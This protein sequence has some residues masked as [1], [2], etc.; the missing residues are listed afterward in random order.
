LTRG[1]KCSHCPARI[2]F[3]LFYLDAEG[4]KHF[5]CLPCGRQLGPRLTGDF[6]SEGLRRIADR[7]G[8]G[9]AL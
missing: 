6:I 5:A 8:A 4:V 7:I 3:G 1:Q 2:R 9:V